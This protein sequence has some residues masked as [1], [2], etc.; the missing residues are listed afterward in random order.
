MLG[1]VA[2]DARPRRVNIEILYDLM[3]AMFIPMAVRGDSG[4]EMECA[5]GKVRLCFLR[6]SAWIIDHLENVR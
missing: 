4:L 6:L 2:R 1:V 3:E 5:D